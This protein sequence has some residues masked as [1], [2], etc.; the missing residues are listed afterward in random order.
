V[1]AGDLGDRTG[2]DGGGDE[3]ARKR[4]GDDITGGLERAADLDVDF[5]VGGI[6]FVEMMLC[7][8]R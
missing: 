3:P 4:R 6:V 7:P 2:G 1:S 5:N 8:C